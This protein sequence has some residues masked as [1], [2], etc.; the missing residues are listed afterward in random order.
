MIDAT[1]NEPVSSA[2]IATLERF[3]RHGLR[4]S[5]P[6]PFKIR[7]KACACGTSLSFRIDQP[8]CN[9]CSHSSKLLSQKKR[10]EVSCSGHGCG[11]CCCRGHGQCCGCP[12]VLRLFCVHCGAHVNVRFFI[13][14]LLWSPLIDLFDCANFNVFSGNSRTSKTLRQLQATCRSRVC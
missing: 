9:C 4:M 2:C 10:Q 7:G 5:N 8:L 1:S 3:P 14:S 12:V 11:C 6:F 13:I